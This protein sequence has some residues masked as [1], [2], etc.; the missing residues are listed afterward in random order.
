MKKTIAMMALVVVLMTGCV[1]I[2]VEVEDEELREVLTELQESSDPITIDIVGG[3]EGVEEDEDEAEELPSSV[4]D[5]ESLEEGDT[6]G[7]M[8]VTELEKRTESWPLGE[9]NSMITF[10]GEIELTGEYVLMDEGYSPMAGLVCVT[11]LDD[12][13]LEVLPLPEDYSRLYFCFENSSDVATTLLDGMTEGEGTFVIDKFDYVGIEG[14]VWNVA[15]LVPS[16]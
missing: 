14:G 5:F 8:V 3:E 1:N 16:M 7:G 13:S 15:R 4:I 11:G 10:E 2:T 9:W 12:E 6:V